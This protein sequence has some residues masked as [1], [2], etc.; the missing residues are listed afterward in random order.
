MNPNQRS[1]K[2]D[3]VPATGL[4]V[5]MVTETY[6]PE[7]NGVAFTLSRLVTG[8]L[9][10]NHH[11]TLIRPRQGSGD[12]PATATGFDEL[13]M[14]GV[15]IPGYRGLRFGMP[16]RRKL[17][18]HWTLH[19]PD[20]VHIATEGPLGLSAVSA[21]E[22]LDLP[23]SSSFHTNFHSY[24]RH[25]G[26]GWLHRAVARHLRQ[27]HN[28]T[29]LTLVPT[30]Y[31]AQQL[32]DEGYR[33]VEVLARGVDTGLF[34]PGRRSGELRASWG[35]AHDQLVIAYIGRMASEKNLGLIGTAYEPIQRVRPDSRLLFVGDGPSLPQLKRQHPH[36]LFAGMR[37]GEDLATHYASADLFLFPSL[38]ETYGNVVPEALASGLPVVAFDCAAASELIRNGEN[39][40]LATDSR[41]EEFIDAAG[42][43]ACNRPLLDSMRKRAVAS[44]VDLSWHR[45]QQAFAGHL[46]STIEARQG[47]AG[48]V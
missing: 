12:Q 38:T 21:A 43:I 8:L 20:I 16:A 28:R 22:A 37:R 23:V 4:R 41:P 18:T 13:L 48:D 31:L 26:L 33:Q 3:Q 24:A 40:F 19:R 47:R 46:A 44:V 14:S 7:V 25:Y 17:Q 34:N 5:A 6:P 2:V 10:A 35:V 29:G 32:R 9:Q 30:R 27:L 11:V 39:G 36:A 42:Q 1:P 45:I 15:P